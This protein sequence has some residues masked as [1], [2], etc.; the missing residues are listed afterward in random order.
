MGLFNDISLRFLN[1]WEGFKA[2]P[3]WDRQELAWVVRVFPQAQREEE[4]FAAFQAG[5]WVQDFRQ[6]RDL[7][8]GSL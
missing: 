6:D 7:G 1:I 8:H 2:R 4:D 3:A 5:A